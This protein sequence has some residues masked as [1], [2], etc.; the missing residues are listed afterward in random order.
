MY[1]SLQHIGWAKQLCY[2][3]SKFDYDIRSQVKIIIRSG[4][5]D[6]NNNK[7]TENG[8]ESNDQQVKSPPPADKVLV[9]WQENGLMGG[10]KRFSMK[11]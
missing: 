8:S 4:Y 7:K 3:I 6:D 9:S 2:T 11:I 1:V 5:G 10:E